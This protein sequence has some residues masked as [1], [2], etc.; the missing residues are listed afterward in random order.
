MPISPP[1]F[2]DQLRET[3][4]NLWMELI[5]QKLQGWATVYLVMELHDP[6]FI[7]S[8]VLAQWFWLA[9][10]PFVADGLTDGRSSGR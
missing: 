8:T 2:D 3:R 6:N 5:L 4:L 10:P 7:T 9:D 1:L